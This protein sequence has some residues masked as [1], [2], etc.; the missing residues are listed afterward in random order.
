MSDSP[1][2]MKDCPYCHR[3]IPKEAT[4]CWYCARELVARPERPSVSDE[5]PSGMPRWLLWG[6]IAAAVVAVILLAVLR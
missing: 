6:L 5:K 4:F 2:E 1:A 3:S